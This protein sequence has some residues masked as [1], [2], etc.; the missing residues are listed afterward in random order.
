MIV[1]YIYRKLACVCWGQSLAKG[2]AG[3]PVWG[4]SRVKGH[5]WREE[6]P[7]SWEERI[8]KLHECAGEETGNFLVIADGV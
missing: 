3:F 4:R 8:Y 7:E 6:T 2:S 1:I 5:W